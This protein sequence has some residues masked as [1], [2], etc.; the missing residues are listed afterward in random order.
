MDRQKVLNF[1]AFDLI[2]FAVIPKT[3]FI[4]VRCKNINANVDG[5]TRFD[6]RE[7]DGYVFD[8]DRMIVVN[9]A[10]STQGEDVT[11]AQKRLRNDPRTE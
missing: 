5:I 9:E 4:E 11:K 3:E 8:G 2:K 7:F 6:I 10:G 1:D